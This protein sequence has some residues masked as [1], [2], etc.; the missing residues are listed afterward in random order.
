[1][2]DAHV[3]ISARQQGRNKVI[4]TPIRALWIDFHRTAVERRP[5]TLKRAAQ[6]ALGREIPETAEQVET[7]VEDARRILDLSGIGLEIESRERWVEAN[8]SAFAKYG[9]TAAIARQMSDLV[10]DESNYVATPERLAF[11]RELLERFPCRHV[12]IASNAKFAI[13]D[14]F[15][16]DHGFASVTVATGDLLG[17]LKPDQEFSKRLIEVTGVPPQNT[18]FVGN[19][20]RND[21]PTARLGVNVVI[22]LPSSVTESSREIT[23]RVGGLIGQVH[24]TRSLE[25]AKTVIE[26]NFVNAR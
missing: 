15:I 19:S 22:I 21:L 16:R 23:E 13:V 17:V 2:H 11:M 3:K 18:L 12:L 25:E 10:C 4:R 6:E 24:I 5:D 20:R 14:R 26:R 8:L 1:M 9:C 7:M